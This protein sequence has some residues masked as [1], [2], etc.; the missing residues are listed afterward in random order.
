MVHR[1]FFQQKMADITIP[2]V[3]AAPVHG[4]GHEPEL[5]D[6]RTTLQVGDGMG[7]GEFGQIFQTDDIGQFFGNDEGLSGRRIPAPHAV[8]GT[9]H[10]IHRKRFQKPDR[11]VF[12]T[13]IGNGFFELE[14]VFENLFPADPP[15]QFGK[16]AFAIQFKTDGPAAFHLPERFPGQGKC[17]GKSILFFP[18]RRQRFIQKQLHDLQSLSNSSVTTSARRKRS[19]FRAY[20]I[21]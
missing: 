18:L 16:I 11:P 14:K 3:Q 15:V 8:P 2:V 17:L 7:P 19:A 9:G 13:G 6:Q 12:I 1:V 21:A 10:G 4:S 5:T 20:C